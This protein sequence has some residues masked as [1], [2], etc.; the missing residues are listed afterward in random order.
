MTQFLPV[1]LR[2]SEQH[3]RKLIPVL[4]FRR[5]RGAGTVRSAPADAADSDETED[6]RH[7]YTPG[8]DAMRTPEQRELEQE[9]NRAF[10]ATFTFSADPALSSMP[11]GNM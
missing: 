2:T 8:N 11:F 9:H 5:G 1:R 6:G 4:L 10:A 7:R 3:T